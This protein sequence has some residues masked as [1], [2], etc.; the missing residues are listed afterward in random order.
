MDEEPKVGEVRLLGVEI[1]PSAIKLCV[2]WGEFLPCSE[3][4]I[5]RLSPGVLPSAQSSEHC[6]RAVRARLRAP[7]CNGGHLLSARGSTSRSLSLWV[8]MAALWSRRY[9]DSP[10]PPAGEA[11]GSERSN[12][13]Y[14]KNKT[15][16]D[17]TNR[18]EL[19]CGTR[20]L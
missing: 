5:P 20:N 9:H 11:A 10:S 2:A 13:V 3:P 17:F 12:A 19:H 1:Q 18:S 14:L 7:V 8:L 6:G 16:S 4:W 15:N